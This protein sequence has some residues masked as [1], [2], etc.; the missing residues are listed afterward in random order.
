[1]NGFF[2][3]M[4]AS[5]DVMAEAISADPHLAAGFNCVGLSQGNNLC[6]G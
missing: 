3:S 6:R 1:M 2:L 4:D 5:V